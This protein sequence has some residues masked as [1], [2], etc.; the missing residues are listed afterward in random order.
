MSVTGIEKEEV[1]KTASYGGF[2]NHPKS[3]LLICT[4]L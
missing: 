1:P 2:R 3:V 4:K